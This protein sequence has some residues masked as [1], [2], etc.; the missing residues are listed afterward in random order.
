[1]IPDEDDDEPKSKGGYTSTLLGDQVDS[2]TME[3]EKKD[4]LSRFGKGKAPNK[5]VVQTKKTS[6]G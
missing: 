5:T 1:M 4:L 6:R 2:K 3:K